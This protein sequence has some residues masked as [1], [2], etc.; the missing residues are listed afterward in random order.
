MT[1]H[2][3]E[4]T[5]FLAQLK[6]NSHK[7]AERNL[8]RQGFCT[9]MPMQE[10]TRRLRGRF[11][12]QPRPLF[13]GYIFV[14]FNMRQGGWRAVNSTHGIT[15]FVGMGSSP[16]PVPQGLVTALKQRCDA[17]SQ[18]V[19]TPDVQ[20]GDRVQIA[21]GPFADF[22]A[23]IEKIARDRRIWVLL[24]IMGQQARVALDEEHFHAV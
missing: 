18:R 8:A 2:H 19:R 13:P 1:Y 10:V 6:P 12:T 4:S 24:D 5:W 17:G 21:K 7:I 11:V 22:V 20:P 9:F 23:T 16:T 3:R 15:R 14:A